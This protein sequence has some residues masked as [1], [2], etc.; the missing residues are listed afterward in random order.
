MTVTLPGHALGTPLARVEGPEKVTGAARYAVEYPVENA[1]HAWIVR[2]PVA[3]GRLR[4]VEL[5][6]TLDGVLAVLWHGNAPELRKPQ[7]PELYVLQDE[8]ISYRGQV[9][10]LVVAETLEAARRAAQSAVLD[11]GEEPHDVV[12]RADHPDLYTP[13]VVN[14]GF[15]AETAQG[16]AEAALAAAPVTVDVTY[17]TP[18]LHNNPMEPH[19][20]IAVWDGDEDLT[21]YDSNQGPWP[22]AAD[23]AST[24]G[25]DPA[26]VRIVAEHVGGGF[27]SKGSARPNAILAAMAAR[28]TGRPVKLALPRQAL[29]SLVGHRT[30]TIQRV[31]LG[32]GPDGTLTAI[33]HDAISQSSRIFEFAEQ[34]AVVT[35]HMYAAANRRT[36]HRLVRLDVPTPRWMRAPGEAPGMVALECAMDELAAALDLDPIELRVRNEPGVEPEEGAPFTSR[37]YLR[38]LREGARRF[39]WDG[40]DHRPARRREGE[41]WRGTG[42]AGATYPAMAAPCTARAR[43]LPDGRVEV[44]VAATDLGTGART[45]L[46]QIAADALGLPV[47]RVTVRIGDTALPKAPVA[48]GSS[49]TASWGWAVDGACRTLREGTADECVFDTAELVEARGNEGRHAFGAHY[50][51]VRVSAVTGEVRVDRLFGMYA[52]GRVLNPRTAR[53]QFIGGMTMGMGMALHEEGVLDP[54]TGDWVNHDLADYHIPAH[55]DVRDIDAAWIDEHDDQLN[56]MGSKGIGE[57]GIVGSPAAILNAIWHA[58]GIRIR[59]LPA[60]MDRILPHLP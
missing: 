59:D 27:G 28:V 23:V 57:I 24:L 48:G 50:A 17:T 35:R 43:R 7:D 60:R 32:A 20:T 58:T 26:R 53:S 39:G 11:I 38:C 10:A 54:H 14:P 42:V 52:V 37:N 31:R 34:T 46:T 45:V 6:P 15:P 3:R 2:S 25:L 13:D 33:T 1:A 30:P 18:A 40:R 51:A 44:S 5:D 4:D 12:L 56:P 36:G 16:D 55:A 47:D 21:L 22:V 19:A 49:G 8:R 41:W 9:I 29:F